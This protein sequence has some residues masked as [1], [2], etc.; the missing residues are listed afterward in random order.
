MSGGIDSPVAAWY[1]MKRGVT[2]VYVHL[3][4][5]QD[6]EDAVKGK[7]TDLL[8]TLSRYY[9]HYKVYFVPSHIF[10]AGSF[11]Y[12]R[13]ELILLKAFMLKLAER[14]ARREHALNVFTGES[15]GQVA[16]QTSGNI[17][18][19]Q[20]GTKLPVLRPLIGFDK[21]EI[22]R[23]ARAI[24]T[25]E[26][27]IRPYKDVCS[28][29]ARNPTLSADPARTREM[30]REMNISSIVTRSLKLARIETM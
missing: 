27:S 13:Y 6:P 10:Q 25:Y 23:V 3:H 26:D 4:A 17:L 19:T 29:N 7:V 18:A 9:P 12:G 16:S 30:L 28:I 20:C 11:K 8:G 5:F 1:A 21:E 2:P 24:G 14:V 15:L 22:I